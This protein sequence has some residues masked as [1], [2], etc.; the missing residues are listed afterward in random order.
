MLE[1]LQV[2]LTAHNAT[3]RLYYTLGYLPRCLHVFVASAVYGEPAITLHILC[4]P[5]AVVNTQIY[6]HVENPTL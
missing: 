2:H 6:C 3:F 1:V 5:P 4:P